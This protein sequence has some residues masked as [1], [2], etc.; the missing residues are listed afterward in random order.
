MESIL[1]DIRYAARILRR[2]PAFSLVA[3]LALA[4]GIGANTAIFS[5]VHA[6]VLKPLPYNDPEQLVQIW[7][8]FTGIGIPDD[9]NAISAPEFMD[10]QRNG[11][12]SHVAAINDRSFNINFGATPERVLSAVVTP[13]FFPLLRVQAQV[14]RVF[15]PEEGQPGNEKVVL[16]TEG[17]WRRRFNADPSVP[18]RKLIM[19]GD[20]YLIAG[21]LP[22]GFQY[23]QES[24]I[25]TPMAFSPDDL[26]P[27]NRGSHGLEVIARIKPGLNI[28]QAR[29][30]MAAVSDRIIR[31]NPTYPYRQYNFTVLL[32]PLL[33]Q[34]VGD[35]KTALWVLMGAVGLVLLIA[36]ANV[37]NLLLVR[38]S[39]REREIAVRQALGV[40]QWRLTRQLLTESLLLA[41]AG[42]AAGLGLAWW[43][44][45]LL[46]AATTTNFPRVAETRLDLPVLVFTVLV[47]VATGVLFGMA[48]VIH[49]ARR[50]SHETLKEGARGSS[51]G[52]ARGMRGALVVAELALSLMLLA[53]AGLLI[54]SFLRLGE[55][56]PG[57]R[58]EGV[59]TMRLSLPPERYTTPQQGHAFYREL[60]ERVRQLPGV[61]SAG[62]TTGLPL[63]RTGWS[64]TATIDTQAVSP[65]DAS[66]EV[67]QRP[68]TPG[69]F[70]AL[71]T[72]LV[73]GRYF[74][75]RDT[76]ASQPVAIVDETL[77]NTYWPQLDP[78]GRRLKTG[79]Y[80]SS[81]PW[82]TVVGVVRHIRYRTLESPSR[83]EFYWPYEQTPYPVGSLSLA[84]HTAADPLTLSRAAQLAVIGLDPNQPVYR[85]RT[86]HELMAESLARRRLSMF[87][88]AIFAG[89]ALVLAAVGIYGVMSYTVAQR[90]HEVGIRMALGARTFDVVRLVL[91][92]S[93][94]LIGAGVLIGVAGSFALTRYLSTM[95]FQ[96]KANDPFTFVVVAVVLGGV[97][98]LASL[99]PTWRAASIDPVNALRQE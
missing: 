75:Q 59:L 3:V 92:Q 63:G 46:I 37:A 38:A 8:R 58:P 29:A 12:F 52:G 22:R 84:I 42:S 28:Q 5:V 65:R 94:W 15:R 45:R 55:I 41:F 4:L 27:N 67:D 80:N 70:E 44:L 76:E 93:L 20:S 88:L 39:A 51:S 11:S 91:G 24:E 33:E 73:R 26:G 90:A 98:M 13:S 68:I 79:G 57:F 2:S 61:D 54:R 47:T 30:D 64:G 1:H 99:I 77:A 23:E 50:S 34:Q 87:L 74:N 95:L 9:H 10:L 83:V 40:S 86:M 32:V 17:L 66:P 62:A 71:G 53:G 14:G 96:V 21:V 16:L 56:D 18:G 36:C 89:V 49:S 72:K 60:L 25:Y 82:R 81:G 85:V 35:I 78:I 43:A 69:Y 6:V 31:D 97:A 19:N 7:G 48:P